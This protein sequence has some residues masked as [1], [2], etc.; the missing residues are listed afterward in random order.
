MRE[1]RS[2]KAKP[3]IGPGRQRALAELQDG[4]A[5]VLT[6][7][8]QEHRAVVLAAEALRADVDVASSAVGQSGH[9]SPLS[10]NLT[11]D[12]IVVAVTFTQDA[13]SGAQQP[14]EERSA[15]VQPPQ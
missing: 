2:L 11:L 15:L 12:R 9:T 3:Q 14:H 7:V 8:A 1:G 13:T 4:R 6:A 5:M 10:R